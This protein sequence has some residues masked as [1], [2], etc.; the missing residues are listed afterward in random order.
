MVRRILWVYGSNDITSRSINYYFDVSHSWSTD[1]TFKM[2][3][4]SMVDAFP[5][6]FR[7]RRQPVRNWPIA[8]STMLRTVSG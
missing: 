1:G 4:S 6:I 3:N 8:A 2:I 7:E 5:S